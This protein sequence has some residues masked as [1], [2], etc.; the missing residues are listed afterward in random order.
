MTK[1]SIPSTCIELTKFVETIKHRTIGIFPYIVLLHQVGVHFHVVGVNS[2]QKVDV[3][4]GMKLLHLFTGAKF[5]FLSQY[6][7]QMYSRIPLHRH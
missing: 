7:G 5:R 2:A 1:L 3:V 4:F 6:L